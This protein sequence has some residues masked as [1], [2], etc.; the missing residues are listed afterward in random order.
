MTKSDQVDGSMGTWREGKERENGDKLGQ[1]QRMR[2]GS[3]AD[4]LERQGPLGMC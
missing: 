3:R 1:T 2:T 4:G